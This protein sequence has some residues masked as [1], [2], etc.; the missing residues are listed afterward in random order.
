MEFGASGIRVNSV[1][2]GLI[3][4]EQAV[5]SVG[6][7]F[8][9]LSRNTPLGRAG[10]TAEIAETVLFLASPRSSFMTGSILTADGGRT[11]A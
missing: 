6:E 7:Q 5:A 4:T 9:E 1:A 10:T 8:D 11:T 2:P 3:R